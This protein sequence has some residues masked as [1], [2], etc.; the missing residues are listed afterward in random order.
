MNVRVGV[1]H[2][3]SAVARTIVE[4]RGPC[5]DG[6]SEHD[7]AATLLVATHVTHVI[8]VGLGDCKVCTLLPWAGGARDQVVV[9]K[10]TKRVTVRKVAKCRWNVGN[11]P[12]TNGVVRLALSSHRILVIGKHG[13][14]SSLR[15]IVHSSL[16]IV[17]RSIRSPRKTGLRASAMAARASES[18]LLVG[19]SLHR[20]GAR[21]A[22]GH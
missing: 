8:A 15:I 13:V 16:R 11:G 6:V 10:L 2:P 3:P 12:V 20:R 18:A 19:A 9:T 5:L 14:H 4:H 7:T 22:A 17:V 1:G 21:H